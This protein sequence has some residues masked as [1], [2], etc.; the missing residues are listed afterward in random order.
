MGKTKELEKK[1][2]KPIYPYDEWKIVE[3]SFDVETNLQD[4][5]IFALGNGYIGFRG[6]F[7]EGY[8]GPPQSS[9]NGT[10]IN[11]FHEAEPIIYGETAYGYAKNAQTMLNVTDSKIIKLYLEDEPFNLF[12]GEIIEYKR[13]LDMKE[14]ILLRDMI[15]K[16]PK[17]KQIQISIRKL[18][19]LSNK[20]LAAISYSVIPLNFNGEISI[21]S[22][23]NGE[24]KN[25][26]S[27]GDPRASSVLSEQ[28]LHTLEKLNEESYGAIKQRTNN[29]QFTLVCSMENEL[30]TS[31]EYT[32]STIVEDQF[33]GKKYIID[34]KQSQSIQLSKFIS[35]VTT[36]DYTEDKLAEL[37]KKIVSTAKQVGFKGLIDEQEQY[38]ARFWYKSDVEIKGDA[39]I[40]QSIRFNQFHLLQSVGK[41]GKTNIGAK[42]L[43]GEGYEGHYFWDTEIYVFPF[44]LYT[45]PEISKKLLEYR[46]HILPKARQRAN[47]V[48]QKGALYAW[49]T[50]NGEETSAYYP[51]STAQYHINADIAYAIKKYMNATDDFAFFVEKGAE[52][53]FETA[54]LWIDLGH[55]SKRKG[56][57]FCIHEVT[58]PDEYTALVNNNAYTNIMVKDHLE[59]AYQMATLMKA[60]FPKGYEALVKK[61]GLESDESQNWEKAAASMYIPDDKELAIIPQDDSFLDKQV[62]DFEN[63]PKENYPLLLHYHPLVI[64]RHQVLKQADLVL[65]LFLQ[66]DRFSLAEKKRN[67]DYYEPITT[68]DSSLSTCIYGIVGAEIGYIE[69]AYHYFLCT[70][71]MDLDDINHNVRDGIHAAAMAGAWLVIVN[72]FA[73]LRE[74]NGSLYLKPIVP[75]GWEEYRFKITFKNRLIDVHVLRDQVEYLLLEGDTIE[76]YH[77]KQSI[78]LEQNK[79][80]VVKKG[81]KI[82]AVIFDLDGVII[83]TAEFHYLA[84]KKLADELNIPFDRAFN[85]RLKGIGRL[86]S[87]D[88]ILQQSNQ[89]YS[90]EEKMLLAKKK[91]EYYQS[92]I[93]V[94]SPKDVLPG[95]KVLLVDLKEHSI[96]IGLASA[97]K[98]AFAV[99]EQLE[100]RDYFDY[101][102][103]AATVKKG[104]PD[105]E[106]FMTAADKL[107]IPYEN[108][109]GIE[110]SQAGITAIKSAGIYAVGIGKEEDLKDADWLIKDTTGL[111]YEVLIKQFSKEE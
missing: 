100:L 27:T 66:G 98:N 53:L 36:I 74:Y 30:V 63:T 13:T 77:Q 12:T 23:I 103:D 20:H 37:G 73:G 5:T 39:A 15:W 3:H 80:M 50:I 2:K 52:I 96:K 42:G 71:R 16:S 9:V 97:S 6:N 85:E 22:A 51:A 47:E 107:E 57:R 41:D 45:N 69:K 88:I 24:V 94:I 11:G 62:W 83:D 91:N 108:C 35:Y 48:G 19:S 8:Y 64:Y 93:Q 76:I 40:Q 29:T 110:D 102:V 38:L 70:A 65:A 78:L 68:H 44:F 21:L 79:K 34:A 26:V 104:K 7:E 105:P 25:Q 14:G 58:G 90:D 56:S 61:I 75:D 60:R 86:E 59:Y 89:T 32:M 95:I 28:V 106:I 92:M 111:S 18:V 67:F 31:N 99:I 109:I 82:E 54:R 87:L 17:G 33:V 49:R 46:Y 84:W 10:Y 4:E 101:M 81:T 72:G 55:Y 1:Y 43:T